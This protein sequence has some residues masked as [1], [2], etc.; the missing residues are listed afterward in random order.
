MRIKSTLKRYA[1]I[2]LVTGL[3]ACANGNF[4]VNH[5]SGSGF[6]MDFWNGLTILFSFV[7]SLETENR[8]NVPEQ[9]GFRPFHDGFQLMPVGKSSAASTV[10]LRP[11]CPH[12]PISPVV[13]NRNRKTLGHSVSPCSS[14][15]GK[16]AGDI[17][18]FH[19]TSLLSCETDNPREI[20]PIT[21]C[22]DRRRY[23]QMESGKTG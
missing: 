15:T 23:L 9:N 13:G 10:G 11:V 1:P 7:A 5:D 22:K 21:A 16:T 2:L 3:S 6:W 14:P 19:Q 12:L 8:R 17:L 4:V 20:N 18:Q